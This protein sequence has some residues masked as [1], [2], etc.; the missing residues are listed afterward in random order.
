MVSYGLLEEFEGWAGARGFF[1]SVFAEH[2]SKRILEIGSG[3]NPALA[4]EDVRAQSIS[5]TTS[6]ISSD[7]LAKADS[8]FEQMVLDLSAESLDPALTESF[9][10]V[11]SR[12]V[13]EHI[14][15]GRQYYSNIYRL[16]RPGGVSAHCFPTLWTLPFAANRL[17][18]EP[19]AD[20]ALGI[21]SPRKDRY[22]HEKFPAYYSWSRGPSKAALQRF[23]SLGFEVLRYSGYFGHAYYKSLP[24]LDRLERWK[25]EQLL[26]HPIPHLCSY[27][28]V[29]LRKP[30]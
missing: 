26:R 10:C 1:K 5:Y 8:A 21:V 18:P 9:D 30:V 2:G 25:S 13:A 24:L 16:L 4:P 29:L 17:L 7:E 6:D 14:R 22:R 27:A 20:L 28:T 11:V 23:Q 3:A 12:M 19:L 15:D